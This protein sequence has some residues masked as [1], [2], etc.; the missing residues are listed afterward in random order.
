MYSKYQLYEVRVALL[1]Y[2]LTF[3]KCINA[4]LWQAFYVQKEIPLLKKK[5]VSN[6]I[7]GRQRLR[8]QVVNTF[9]RSILDVYCRKS[10]F[11]LLVPGHQTSTV[12]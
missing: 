9:W 2:F 5:L 1:A 4:L 3:F 8:L 6:I 7:S 10:V 12:Q 11:A